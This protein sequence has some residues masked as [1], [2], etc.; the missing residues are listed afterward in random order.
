MR[1]GVDAA[2]WSN[3]RG[4]G[5][6]TRGLLGALLKSGSRH[7]FLLFMDE[8][9]AAAATLPD[10][11][12]TISVPTSTAPA[13][14]ASAGGRRSVR[15]LLRMSS[16]VRRHRIDLF[17][18]PT[19]YTYFPI[20]NRVP[21]V[22]GIHDTIAEDYPEL[23]FPHAGERRL[24]NAKSW[25]A[26]R[27]ARWVMTVSDYARDCIERRFAWPSDRI[28]VVG[29]AADPAFPLSIPGTAE[30]ASADPHLVY[31]GGVNPHKNLP[32]LIEVFARLRREPLHHTLK[33][34][35]VGEVERETFTPGAARVRETIARLGVGEA[36][37]F[38]GFLPDA[39]AATLLGSAKA[40]VLP[41][42]S[43]GFGLPAIEAAACGTP[44]VATRNSPLPQLLEGGGI[45]FDP[46]SVDELAGALRVML[47]DEPARR[48]MGEAARVAA[49]KLSWGRSAR[50]FMMM[51]DAIERNLG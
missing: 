7:Q 9:T 23:V 28:F 18:F 2:S 43:E 12:Q 11:A 42:F 3:L 34:I 25:L 4:Y 47:E 1:I 35:I 8:E 14:A 26:R 16:A 20:F 32:A 10:H 49:G 33:L 24:W 30:R 38:T 6:F 17:V 36:V 51:I 40:L 39:G 45:F 22:V 21:V 15:D 46:R 31:L 13:K 44:V 41:S 48:R 5:R 37:R 27:Q 29:E 19:I 50:Q